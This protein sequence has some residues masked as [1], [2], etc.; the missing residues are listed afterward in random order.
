MESGESRE[1][2]AAPFSASASWAE[3]VVAGAEI[4]GGGL[5]TCLGSEKLGNSRGQPSFRGSRAGSTTKRPVTKRVSI[6][7]FSTRYCH[8][9]I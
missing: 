6:G 1:S 9:M 4:E 7:G 3:S 5:K 2:V 8:V